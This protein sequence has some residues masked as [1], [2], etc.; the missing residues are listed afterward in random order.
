MVR[1]VE[2]KDACTHG[3][4]ARTARMAVELGQRMRLAPDRLRVIARGA[5]L[6]D[7]GYEIASAASSLREG[8]TI[9]ANGTAEEAWQAA[10]T[11]H[12]L[13]RNREPAPA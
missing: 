5:Y 1:A 2:I 10:Q 8:I 11:C 4:S 9:G 3:H 12:E 13:D 6:H 7:L